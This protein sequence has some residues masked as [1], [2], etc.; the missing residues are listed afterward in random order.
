MADEGTVYVAD[1][2]SGPG[3]QGIPRGTVKS[4]RVFTYHFAY[5]KQAGIQHRVGADGPWEVKQVLGTVPV[6]ADG[7]AYFRV[8]A[9]TPI[10]LQPLDE[11]GKALQLM[12]SWMTVMPG[13][14]RSCVGCHEDNAGVPTQDFRQ[15][16][17]GLKPP[18]RSPLVRADRAGSHSPRGSTSSRQVLRW[19]PRWFAH[20]GRPRPT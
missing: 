6:E 5:Q 10:S 12:R 2:Y 8:P 20:R 11:E 19:V 15:S 3:L 14:T 16:L 13:E 17:A 4:L 18:R 1:I 9:K 7:S